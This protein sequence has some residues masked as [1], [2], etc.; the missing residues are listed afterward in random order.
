M[1]GKENLTPRQIV[2]ELD[3]YIV[4]QANAKRAV[5]I[6]LRNRYRRRRLP[7]DLRD[8]VIPK[9]I[10]MIGP[11]G[12]G[13]TEIARRLARLANAPFVKV[14]ATKF[15]EVGYVGRDVDS[16]VRDL[17]QVAYQMVE[18]EAVE[19]VQDRAREAAIER[20]V[21]LLQPPPQRQEESDYSLSGT[22]FGSLG[23]PMG[24]RG[25]S[26]PHEEPESEGRAERERKRAEQIERIRDR[27]REQVR[28]GVIEERKVELEVEEGPSVAFM[29]AFSDAGMEEIGVNLGEMFGNLAPKRRRK[30][31]VTVAE[32]REILTAEEA[33]KMIDKEQVKRDAVLR[34]EQSGIIFVDEMDK[35]AGK[36]GGHG[37]DVSRG[38][39]QRDILPIIEGSTVVTKYGSVRPDHVLFIAA[40]AFH[41]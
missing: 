40:G 35:I 16:M 1:E 34:A 32:A 39:V 14:E 31:T 8:E 17:A 9:N 5:A 29:P 41:I 24:S 6:A 23:F 26:T 25:A 11:T 38:G 20:V 21:D 27:L 37:P 12:V 36:E 28:T 10:L 2:A 18:S 4:G 33:R 7:D 19:G 3:R 30:R 22:I 15:T 13:K